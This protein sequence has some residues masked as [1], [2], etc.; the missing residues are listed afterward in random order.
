MTASRAELVGVLE[1]WGATE[2]PPPRADFLDELEAR[3]GLVEPEPM[4]APAPVVP[5]QSRRRGLVLAAVAAAVALVVGLATVR[6]DQDDQQT[7]R[8]QVADDGAATTSSTAAPETSDTTAAPTTRGT[9]PRPVPVAPDAP[10]D[11]PPAPD[12]PD[13]PPTTAAEVVPTEEP[14]PSVREFEL[15][16]WGTPARVFLEWDRYVG[17]DF[18]A[19]QV[20][21]A[22]SPDEPQ[23]G[24]ERTMMELRIEDRNTTSY[25][26]TPKVGTAP[27]RYRIAVV[28]ADG[29]LIAI[30]N[31][32]EAQSNTSPNN[33]R[34]LP[35]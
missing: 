6:S 15:R 4:V 29:R 30:S 13:S 33:T 28:D 27:N 16:G 22:I 8:L 12:A 7:D 20:L 11:V 10:D 25:D 31:V 17:E 5:L 3:L 18:A 23:H 14:P 26:T 35:G 1:A 34:R 32:V 21:R 2:V 9:T 19:Y 24:H